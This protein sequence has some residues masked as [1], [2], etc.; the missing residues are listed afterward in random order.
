M[1]MNM[2]IAMGMK[3]DFGRESNIAALGAAKLIGRY[4]P[5]NEI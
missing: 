1:A 2:E 3:K 5:G 4:D